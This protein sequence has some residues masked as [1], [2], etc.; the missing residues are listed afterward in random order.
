MKRTT[1]IATV[2]MTGILTL[3]LTGQASAMLNNGSFDLV[4]GNTPSQ[5]FTGVD[6]YRVKLDDP[7]HITVRSRGMN[8]GGA[9]HSGLRA[10]LRDGNGNI[11]T[12]THRRGGDF[13]INERLD[14]G[15]YVLEVHPNMFGG[16]ADTSD[17]YYL[18]TRI[19]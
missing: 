5:R 7:S 16:R 1:T 12:Q 9:P 14:A 10:V 6:H 17:H 18:N 11:V 19:E 2:V 4:E 15:E 8:S 3:G 13:I